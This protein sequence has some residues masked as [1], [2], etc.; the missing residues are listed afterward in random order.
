MTQPPPLPTA[1]TGPQTTNTVV[2]VLF[3]LL[4]LWTLVAD[5]RFPIDMMLQTSASGLVLALF[6]GFWLFAAVV[7]SVFP[8][9]IVIAASVLV[10]LR[11]SIGWPLNLVMG[12]TPASQVISILTF[13]LAAGYLVASLKAWLGIAGRPWVQLKHFGLMFAFWLV[14]SVVSLVPVGLGL[15]QAFDNFAGSYVDLSIQG[16][17]VKERVFEK[18][19]KRVRL[20]GMVH[21]AD[22]SFYRKLAHRHAPPASERHLVLTEGVSDRNEVLPQSFASGETYARLAAKL[23]LEPQEGP[24][25]T[26]APRPPEPQPGFTF[27]NADSDVS[28]LSRKHQELLVQLLTFLDEAE[29]HELF[30][31]PEGVTAMDVHDLFMNG[32]IGSRNDHLMGVFDQQL[33]D[34]DEVHI[35]W[36]AAHLPDIEQR[37]LTRGYRIVEETDQHAIDFLKAFR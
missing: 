6:T 10:T 13:A 34:Y 8:K 20:T 28:D 37:L 15:L 17:S 11:M 18:D 30:A 27:L 9:R 25:E 16:M 24:Q 21:I 19:G 23:G 26:E 29:L 33:A 3:L 1:R 31:M 5:L 7:T 36:G 4:S 12:N 22:P 35:P 32:L 2:A 14:Y